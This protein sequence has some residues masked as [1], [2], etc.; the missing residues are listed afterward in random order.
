MLKL[1]R[2][3]LR[4]PTEW[5][6]FYNLFSAY[7]EEVCDDDEY[8]EEIADLHDETLNSQMIEQTLREHNP[9]FI[10]RI[11]LNEKCVGLISYSYDEKSFLGFINNFYVCPEQ[12]STGIGSAVLRMVET[13]LAELCAKQ[14][15]LI[16]VEKAKP[17]YVRNGFVQTRTTNDGKQV[18][19]KKI[20]E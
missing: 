9:Y 18:F 6:E 17:F 3:D 11:V 19:G 16:P 7:L 20:T 10:M 2:F 13:H 4:D 15:D 1:V 14:V 8:R 12:R 5:D